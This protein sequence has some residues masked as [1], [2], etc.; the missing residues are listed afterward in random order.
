[1]EETMFSV[2]RGSSYILPVIAAALLAGPKIEFDTKSFDCGTAIEGKTD[3][4]NATF[5]VKNTG[6]SELKLESVRPGCGCTVVKYDK[7]IQPGKTA[8]IKA[9]VDI[10]GY[11][12]GPLSKS[13]TVTSNAENEPAI[14]LTI[15]ATV[16]S[17]V[18]VSESYLSLGKETIGTPK[19]VFLSSK[20][21]DLKVSDISFKPMGNSKTPE[22]KANQPLSIKHTWTPTDSIRTDGYRVFKLNLFSPNPEE[23][24]S[25]EFIIKTNH[26]DKPIITFRGNITN[27]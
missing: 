9:E 13:V 23:F 24:I 20:K 15:T 3:K 8:K 6:D 12:S 14:R 25:G 21:S 10:A 2:F 26:P 19:T 4:I 17:V 5:A 18:D 16:V 7:L 22:P 1:M 27:N 11:R